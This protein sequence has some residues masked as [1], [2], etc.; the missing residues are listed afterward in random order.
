MVKW[1]SGLIFMRN[2]EGRYD[3]MS[4]LLD[5]YNNRP[6][7]SLNLRFAES[8]N[9]AFIRKMPQECWFWIA[10]ETIQLV[11]NVKD[12]K[13]KAAIISGKDSVRMICLHLFVNS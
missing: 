11:I 1:R 5:W 2:I 13:K 6:H 12:V 8:P 4:E 3:S 9:Q 10:R 7:G